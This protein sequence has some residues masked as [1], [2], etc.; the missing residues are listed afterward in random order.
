MLI[1]RLANATV[2]AVETGLQQ[3]QD[4]RMASVGGVQWG[5]RGAWLLQAK[6]AV[7]GHADSLGQDPC[8]IESVQALILLI[9]LS[10]GIV[11]IICAVAFFRED[12]EEQIT[13]LCP[14]LVVKDV[15][16][17]FSLPLDT[18]A[19]TMAVTD[20]ASNQPICKVVF[21]WPDP[22]RPGGSGVA[23]TA[24]LQNTLDLT[25]GTVVAR[26]VAVVGQG[27]ALCR[28]GCEIFGFVEPEGP[29]RYS[30][31]HRT[32][33]HLLTL[34]GDFEGIDIEGINPVGS[35]VCWFK[36][37]GSECQGRVLQH[38]DAGLVI[39][40][41][42]ATHVHQRLTMSG[43]PTLPPSIAV[44]P[45]PYAPNPAAKGKDGQEQQRSAPLSQGQAHEDKAAGATG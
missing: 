23:A 34:T 28:A 13:P 20:P 44:K 35:K 45:R 37:V 27:L 12:K 5:M 41:L 2:K 7:C 14:Q 43:P 29:R 16:Q 9:C 18:Q 25:L 42:L 1:Q 30:V 17:S 10:A 19:D 21:D 24:R 8:N 32:G 11:S 36:K 31:R 38:V 3:P 4:S 40:S 15:D 33:V 39:C 6:A 22:L 26:N